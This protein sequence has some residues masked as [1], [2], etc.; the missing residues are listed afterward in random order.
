M[1]KGGT[2]FVGEALGSRK[3]AKVGRAV[4]LECMWNTAVDDRM[5]VG[6][7]ICGDMGACGC[8]FG[9][10]EVVG[11]IISFT[12]SSPAPHLPPHPSATSYSLFL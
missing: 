12:S 2:K 8:V 4:E 6:Q 7:D 3:R 10:G 9:G 1:G 5:H 11:V